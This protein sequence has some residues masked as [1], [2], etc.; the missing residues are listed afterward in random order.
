M[1]EADL[2]NV[3]S[4]SSTNFFLGLGTALILESSGIASQRQC[5]QERPALRFKSTAKFLLQ[6]PGGC[7]HLKWREE[8]SR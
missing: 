1:F 2:R 5:R 6:A 8:K 4:L 7:I 3:D